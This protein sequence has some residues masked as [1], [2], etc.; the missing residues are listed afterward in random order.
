MGK[1]MQGDNQRRRALARQSR[2]RGTP[3]DRPWP[4]PDI[5]TG[6]PGTET[7][8]VPVIRYRE[9]VQGVGRR[10][11]EDFP[12]ARSGAEA[13]VR[14]LAAALLEPDRELLLD[15]VPAELHGT[16][17]GQVSR[18]RDLAGFLAEVARLCRRT[19]EQARYQA[20]ATLAALAEQDPELVA[21]LDLPADLADL[22]SPLPVG[23]D[24]PAPGGGT[25][26]LP[27]PELAL[28]LAALPY[29]S[30]QEHALV[31][32]IE[33]PPDNLDRVL[34]RLA[35]IKPET[36]RGPSIGRPAAG[37]AVLTVRTRRGA[38][39]TALDVALAH[40]VDAAIDEAGAGMI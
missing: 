23:A 18:R 26:P 5:P 4:Y 25:A 2:Q 38:G 29:W 33:L 28:A 37:S 30:V 8:T 14:A 21:A 10:T 35:R 11:G 40:Q 36:G 15:A 6:Q 34:Q 1:Q 19:P 24:G 39:I 12:D 20:Q 7:A 22:R 31:R 32:S 27:G 16:G 13:T 9:L 17:A 3:A